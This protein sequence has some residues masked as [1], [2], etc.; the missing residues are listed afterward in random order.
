MQFSKVACTGQIPSPR[1]WHSTT[2]LTSC[3]SVCVYGG[4]DGEKTLNDVFIFNQS[5]HFVHMTF[6]RFVNQHYTGGGPRTN[7]AFSNLL[8]SRSLL[9]FIY[10]AKD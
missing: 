8:K 5:K 3:K 9:T 10:Q 6:P 1:T 7:F 4:Y 2:I